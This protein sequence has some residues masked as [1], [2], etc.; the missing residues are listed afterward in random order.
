MLKRFADD[1]FALIYR[2]SIAKGDLEIAERDFSP[3]SIKDRYQPPEVMRQT[4]A[5]I[6]RE[7]RNQLRSDEKPGPLETITKFLPART[8][9][10]ILA[11]ASPA[12]RRSEMR[13]CRC[14]PCRAAVPVR[15][16]ALRNAGECAA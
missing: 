1:L 10:R 8:H 12:A 15:R 14:R 16:C 4:K 5:S 7:Q 13:L 9:L 6:A 2:Q 11:R 3:V